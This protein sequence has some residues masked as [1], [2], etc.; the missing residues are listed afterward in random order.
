MKKL[1]YTLTLFLVSL[2][3]YA[4]APQAVCY[5]GVAT[6]VEGNEMNSQL[7]SIRA[8]IIKD[9]ANGIEEWVETHTTNTD[10]FGLFSLDVGRGNRQG[11]AQTAFMDIDW[12]SG[13]YFLRIE[14]DALGGDDYALMGTTQ[15]LSVPYSLHAGTAEIATEATSAEYAETAGQAENATNADNA[16]NATYAETAGQAENAINAQMAETAI[17]LVGPNDTDITNELQSLQQDGDSLKLVSGASNG[18][19]AILLNVDDADADATNELQTL[20]YENGML[21]I[22]GGNAI[23]PAAEI[24]F[25]APGASSDF[26]QGIVGEHIILKQE[27]YQVP[28]G[29]TLYVTAGNHRVNMNGYGTA[30]GVISHYTTPNMPVFPE[31]TSISDCQCTGI[32]VENNDF[33]TAVIID[34]YSMPSYTVP[35]DMILFIKSGLASDQTGSLMVNDDLMEFFR[36]NFTRG[37]RIISFPELTVLKKPNDITEMVLTGYL[38]SKDLSA[39][40]P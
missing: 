19:T 10:E 15:L 33:V 39:I 3:T 6:D 7:I 31:N 32:L 34:F 36:P 38:M 11:G 16:A 28:A 35:D 29:K 13:T 21:S 27:H 24:P 9:S 4:Q 22:S 25:G 5:Q 26:P 40:T 30:T 37:T 8:S 18:T 17:S 23:N 1:L 14:M 20:S 12:K 2:V